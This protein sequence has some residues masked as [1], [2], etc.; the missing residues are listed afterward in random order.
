MTTTDALYTIA[1]DALYTPWVHAFSKL[2]AIGPGYF[3][4]QWSYDDWKEFWS[5]NNN[6]RRHELLRIYKAPLYLF[7][8][9]HISD[10]LK[11]VQF[12][13]SDAHFTRVSPHIWKYNPYDSPALP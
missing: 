9:E 10:Y 8:G 1:T 13:K 6:E 12:I 7:V 11:Y 3:H 2:P 5:G 4:D